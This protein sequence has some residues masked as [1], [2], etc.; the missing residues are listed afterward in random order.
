MQVAVVAY[1]QGYLLR[2]ECILLLLR[3]T[4][5]KICCG[6]AM[7]SLSR[8]TSQKS[9]IT[10]TTL[11]PH[12]LHPPRSPKKEKKKKGKEKETC[13]HFCYQE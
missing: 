12:P 4:S 1:F 3:W 13:T 6:S 5:L 2:V 7:N 9:T 10:S 11:S 8:R